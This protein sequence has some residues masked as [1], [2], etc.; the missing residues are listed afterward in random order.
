MA[1]FVNSGETIPHTPVAAKSAGD[2]VVLASEIIGVVV[3]DIEAG[4]LGALR[5]DGTFRFDTS[6]TM[7]VGESAYYNATADEITDDSTDVYAGRVVE[8][9]GTTQVDVKLVFPGEV[10][11]S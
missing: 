4:K 11:G 1:D 7:T 10:A 3:A 5:V 8:L 6:D 9:I 2:I